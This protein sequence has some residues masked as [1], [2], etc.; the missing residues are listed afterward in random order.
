MVIVSDLMEIASPEIREAD[1]LLKKLTQVIG[2]I[3]KEVA[4]QADRFFI[5]LYFFLNRFVVPDRMAPVKEPDLP[6]RVAVPVLQK[7]AEEPG[8]PGKFIHVRCGVRAAAGKRR[9]NRGGE[10]RRKP[11]VRVNA[12][13]PVVSSLR[14]GE[15]PLRTESHPSLVDHISPEGSRNL[16]RP[17]TASGVHDKNVFCPLAAFQTV[18]EM[19]LFVFRQDDDAEGEKLPAGRFF[20]HENSLRKG[21]TGRLKNKRNA[22]PGRLTRGGA[23]Q[24]LPAAGR[25]KQGGGRRPARA[26]RG[27]QCRTQAGSR[28]CC[29]QK[30]PQSS[31][32]P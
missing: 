27:C 11:F 3:V 9:L 19:I 17:I 14:D 21:V 1:L 2:R 5:R 29:S 32:S 26:F 4:F 13:H 30:A 6:V 8:L 15:T 10:F 12:E 16:D 22:R 23:D 7:T 20:R 24:S 25:R 28:I 18:L 31:R